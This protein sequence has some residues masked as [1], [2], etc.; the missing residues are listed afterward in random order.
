MSITLETLETLASEG[1]RV[2]LSALANDPDLLNDHAQ[3]RL[4]TQLRKTWPAEDAG[5]ALELARLRHKAREKFGDHAARLFFTREALEQSSDPL[6]RQYRV[7]A[8]PPQAHTIDLCCSIGSDS[9]AFAQQG[10][11]VLGLD[12]DPLRIRIAQLNAKALGLAATFR[13]YDAYEGQPQACDWLFFDPARRHADGQ[14]IFDVEAYEPPLSLVQTWQARQ[15][16]IIKLSP[17]VDVAQVA[18]YGGR[19]EFVSVQGDLKEALLWQTADQ[20]TTS[21]AVLLTTEAQHHFQRNTPTPAEPVLASPRGYVCEPDPSILRAG[22]VSD[23]AAVLGCQMLDR[24]IAYLTSDHALNSPWVRTWQVLDWLPFNMKRVR[25]YLRE[26]N[27][28]Q[29]TIKKRGFPMT[30]E[31]ILPQLKLRGDEARTLIF[32][33]ADTQRIV[34]VCAPQLV[35]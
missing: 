33:R 9:L 21:R 15:G 3:L 23:L 19:L 4:L 28:G 10:A 7:Q 25:E 2:V 1:G 32:T 22:L 8:I 5:A 26:R 14:R 6:V 24:T 17:G 20:D 16:R 18:T 31:E 34:I 11:Q 30:P 35:R 29:V 12:R 27:V 13:V